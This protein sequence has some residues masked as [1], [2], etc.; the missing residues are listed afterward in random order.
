MKVAQ[1]GT[2]IIVIHEI[3][4]GLHG[5][6]H[7]KVP[8]YLSQF[9]NLFVGTVFF[10]APILAAILLWTPFYRAGSWLLL[11][12]LAGSLLFGLYIHFNNSSSAYVSRVS[13]EGWGLLFQITVILL[14]VVDSVGCWLGVRV[15][16]SMQ[17]PKEAT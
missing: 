10:L 2:A 12:S 3:V 14:I 5:L 6:A 9:E 8:V 11:S 13:W 15:L 7:A 4:S 16:Q 17:Q 1:Y